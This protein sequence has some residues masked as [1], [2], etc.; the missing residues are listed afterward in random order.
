MKHPILATQARALAA[1]EL[2]G[3]GEGDAAVQCERQAPKTSV[4]R[5]DP[6]RTGRQH[7]R[8]AMPERTNCL[9][10]RC[11]AIYAVYRVL[12]PTDT[13]RAGQSTRALQAIPRGYIAPFFA[14]RR[15]SVRCHTPVGRYTPSIKLGRTH[16]V[17]SHSLKEPCR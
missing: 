8:K 13:R 14:A 16:G 2:E 10:D 9:V 4:H 17:Q 11:V 5:T 1:W 15:V 7:I 3:A 12:F 6:S